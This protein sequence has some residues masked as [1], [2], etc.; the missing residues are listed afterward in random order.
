MYD[1][2]VSETGQGWREVRDGHPPAERVA[3]RTRRRDEAFEPHCYV[4]AL[5]GRLEVTAVFDDEHSP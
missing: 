3:H 4:E 1:E 5:G 2:Y